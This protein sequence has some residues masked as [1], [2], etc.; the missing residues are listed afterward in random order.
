MKVT[1]VIAD[2][3][4][5][6]GVATA[7]EAFESANILHQAKTQKKARIF[8]VETA[9][10]DGKPVQSQG[11]L[12]LAPEKKL[13]EV[14]RTDLILV[15]GFL[16]KVL[17]LLPNLTGIL[18]W[19]S[20][21]YAQKA[22]IASMCTGSF[23]IAEA[24]LLDAKLATTHWY[25]ASEFKRRYPSVKLSEQ[26]TVTEDQGIICSGGA[27]AANDM[28]LH[29]IRKFVSNELASECSKKML[30]DTGRTNQT[31]YIM[32]SFRRNH[33]DLNVKRVQVWLD[34]NF[35]STIAFEDVAK[36]FGFGARNF[37][38]RFK[39]ATEMT[40]TEYLQNLRIEKAKYLLETTK[41]SVSK[42]TYE[43]GYQDTSS[44]SKLFKDR[45]NI[46]PCDYRKKFHLPTK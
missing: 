37:T 8:D 2:S 41:H 36:D 29:L 14:D 40:P 1:V 33:E 3:C 45:V 23:L 4:S 32:Q 26:H 46:S 34:D 7:L 39:T 31:P 5:S 43:V 35:M 13:S 9:S 25:F 44:F 28:L 42:I 30:V 15:P 21:H 11:G 17:S 6:A 16:F 22:T 12:A 38:R 10:L 20:K 27:T 19:L 18:P 24:G